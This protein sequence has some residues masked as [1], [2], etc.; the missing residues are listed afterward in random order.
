[1][2]EGVQDSP[3]A[4]AAAG[5]ATAAAKRGRAT[6]T[7]ETRV[8]T[9][10]AAKLGPSTAAAARV[11]TRKEGGRWGRDAE[12]TAAMH[13]STTA[14]SHGYTGGDSGKCVRVS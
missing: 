14:V 7:A 11:G 4:A 8:A 9:Q 10:A 1:M 5:L 12:S 13:E 6:A 2:R 3:T